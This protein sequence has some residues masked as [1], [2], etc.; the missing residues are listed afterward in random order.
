LLLLCF[1]SLHLHRSLRTKKMVSLAYKILSWPFHFISLKAS[2]CLGLFSFFCKT[3]WTRDIHW[4][5][6]LPLHLNCQL[7]HQSP[8][9]TTFC[10]ISRDLLAK[11]FLNPFTMLYLTSLTLAPYHLFHLLLLQYKVLVV[12]WLFLSLCWPTAHKEEITLFFP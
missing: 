2:L 8:H 3:S 11:Y 6:P 9:E 12:I 10:K 7:V 5:Y 1:H 4:L